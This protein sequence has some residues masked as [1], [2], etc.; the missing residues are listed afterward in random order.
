MCCHN[1]VKF[2]PTGGEALISRILETV[3]QYGSQADKSN[4]SDALMSA[5]ALIMQ[6]LRSDA[7]KG[8][9]QLFCTFTESMFAEV[10][11]WISRN[12]WLA[13]FCFLRDNEL[14]RVGNSLCNQ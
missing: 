6:G 5:V 11:F 12:Y 9:N 3:A 14:Q 13:A 10:S 1:L 8:F 4:A 7:G 2:I